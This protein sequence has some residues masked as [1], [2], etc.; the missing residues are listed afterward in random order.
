MGVKSASAC[1]G[2][3]SQGENR[4][5]KVQARAHAEKNLT[6][7]FT[8]K[9]LKNS[10]YMERNMQITSIED[11]YYTSMQPTEEKF[12]MGTRMRAT[13]MLAQPLLL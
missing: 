2:R 1:F 4:I 6:W 9:V 13:A 8:E 12:G 5:L 7:E 3:N 11:L 10:G